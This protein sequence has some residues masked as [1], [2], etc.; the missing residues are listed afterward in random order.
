MVRYLHGNHYSKSIRTRQTRRQQSISFISVANKKDIKTLRRREARQ[1]GS[2][3]SIHSFNRSCVLCC[4]IVFVFGSRAMHRMGARGPAMFDC[5]ARWPGILRSTSTHHDLTWPHTEL[6]TENPRR[7][8]VFRLINQQAF[9]LP[10]IYL[11]V[12]L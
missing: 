2:A 4:C 1:G 3:D 7:V 6:K 11:Q 12:Q 8:A 10:C 9:L 5:D